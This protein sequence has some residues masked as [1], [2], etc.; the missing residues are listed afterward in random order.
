MCT[1]AP[2]LN[3]RDKFALAESLLADLAAEDAAGQPA[4]VLAD[5]LR[6]M[7]RID[8]A[9][10]AL[11]ARLLHGFDAQQGS[12]CDGQR[13][14]RTWL[15]NCLRVTKGQAGEYKAIQALA[16]KHGP[17]LAGL[18][19]RA[20]T[21]SVA[22]LLARWTMAIPGEFRA[23][24]EEI[25]VTAARAGVGLPS[26]AAMCAEIRERTA[27]PDPDDDPADDP[28]LDRAVVLDTTIDGVGV[29]RGDLTAECAAMVRSVLDALSAP[30]GGGDLRTGPQRCHDALEEAMR[31]LLA[32][33]LLPKR[34]GQPVK[35]LAHIHFTELLAMD[36][37][38]VLQDTWITE[39][40]ARWAARR[41]AASAG[42]SDG[43]A[44]LTGEAARAV[45][46][47]AMIVPVVTGDLDP[48]ALEDLIGLCV[49]YD[50]AR[51]GGPDPAAPQDGQPD[52]DGDGDGG[53][54]TAETLGELEQQILARVIQR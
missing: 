47:D 40:R 43:G 1:A 35:A 30:T 20:L 42:P 2:P 50:R 51:H 3:A 6:A 11:R 37:D 19:D 18:R 39:Y 27:G 26:L 17:L 10:A 36:Q 14:T 53:G 29:L 7:E 22:L 24:A 34:A 38:S 46:C 45:A 4:A 31:R 16:A 41:A 49:R 44:W 48:A 13:T 23:E 33:G 25:L 52:A 12:V 15:V 54:G 8:A 28:R 21:K 32:S 9:G 5:G